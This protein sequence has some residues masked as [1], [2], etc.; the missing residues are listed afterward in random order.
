MAS[1][2]FSNVLHCSSHHPRVFGAERGFSCG[3]YAKPGLLLSYVTLAY[4]M[5]ENPCVREESAML[6]FFDQCPLLLHSLVLPLK[7]TLSSQ[8][9]KAQLH[10]RYLLFFFS[11]AKNTRNSDFREQSGISAPLW[12][13]EKGILF[14]AKVQPTP[15]MQQRLRIDL[16]PPSYVSHRPTVSRLWPHCRH[17]APQI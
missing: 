2:S 14:G 9:L 12:W 4:K 16:I 3:I 1:G 5:Q 10:R 17:P 15:S 6:V 8:T 11:L 7:L 13:C